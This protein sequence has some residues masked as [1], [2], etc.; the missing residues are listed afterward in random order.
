MISIV[1]IN[2]NTRD[3]T[4]KC[5]AAVER[6][7]GADV[8]LIIVDNGSNDGSAEAFKSLI[9]AHTHLLRLSNNLGFAGG[10]NGERGRED[11]RR[12]WIRRRSF[13][14]GSS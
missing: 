13:H 12:R 2:W 9:G 7:R 3:T 10:A 8:E 14:R 11:G 4:L 5:L 1:V 6:H